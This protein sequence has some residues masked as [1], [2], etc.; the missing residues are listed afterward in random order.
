M[1]EVLHIDD[2]KDKTWEFMSIEFLISFFCTNWYSRLS[3]W[4]FPGF[5]FCRNEFWHKKAMNWSSWIFNEDFWLKN[6]I[7]EFQH[8]KISLFV[9]ILLR[10]RRN[11]EILQPVTTVIPKHSFQSNNK[12]LISYST[13]INPKKIS[14]VN[15]EQ[16]H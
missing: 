4:D 2:L 10:S 9:K 5:Y 6:Q 8:L 13:T 12:K 15:Q 1:K 3:I 7:L 14:F 16:H 11:I